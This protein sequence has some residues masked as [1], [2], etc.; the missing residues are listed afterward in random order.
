M[1]III[2][3][4]RG[5][6]MKV[7]KHYSVSEFNINFETK[8]KILCFLNRFTPHNLRVL[9]KHILTNKVYDVFSWV[10]LLFVYLIILEPFHQMCL[11]FKYLF[12]NII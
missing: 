4:H 12:F 6:K 9:Q 3:L 11:F 10:T 7:M 1:S 5:K 8:R 2:D